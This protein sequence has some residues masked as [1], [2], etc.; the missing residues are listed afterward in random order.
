MFSPCTQSIIEYIS[1]RSQYKDKIKPSF[2]EDFTNVK[3]CNESISIFSCFIENDLHRIE[4]FVLIENV[5]VE[6]LISSL[7]ALVLLDNV[8]NIG[9][10]EANSFLWNK[11][12]SSKSVQQNPNFSKKKLWL[13]TAINEAVEVF[14]TPGVPVMRMFGLFLCGPS[15]L[16][17]AVW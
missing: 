12:K 10:F 2:R 4:Q 16:M 7:I 17:V 1:F 6:L 5:C 14:P 9:V 15:S 11:I 13:L 8:T 3:V